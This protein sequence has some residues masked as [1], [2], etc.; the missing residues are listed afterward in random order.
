MTRAISQLHL[1]GG[2]GGGSKPKVFFFFFNLKCCFFSFNLHAFLKPC[3]KLGYSICFQNISVTENKNTFCTFVF[4]YTQIA[5]EI[6]VL[7]E[8]LIR[9]KMHVTHYIASEYIASKR[10]D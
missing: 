9:S 8:L 1:V 2:G 4:L 7:Y 6:F 3:S 10:N 5:R